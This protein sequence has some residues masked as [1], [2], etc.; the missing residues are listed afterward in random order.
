MAG[1]C[2]LGTFAIRQQIARFVSLGLIP[3]ETIG[4]QTPTKN[5]FYSWNQDDRGHM[6]PRFTNRVHL[7]YHVG[8]ACKTLMEGTGF[9]SA[10]LL[11]VSEHC[12]TFA[13]D[14][15]ALAALAALPF[16][17]GL[18]SHKREVR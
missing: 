8:I 14:A 10:G 2:G 13:Y 7:I 11:R 9:N 4:Q 16:S 12:G 5:P 6:L 18:P 17:S 15:Q 1:Y 3:Q